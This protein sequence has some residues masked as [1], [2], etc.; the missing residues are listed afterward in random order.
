MGTHSLRPHSRDIFTGRPV[1]TPTIPPTLGVHE[2]LSATYC[3]AKEVGLVHDIQHHFAHFPVVHG[4]VVVLV[5]PL[6]VAEQLHHAGQGFG[7]DPDAVVGEAV[8]LAGL[9]AFLL[10]LAAVLPLVLLG[11][12]EE[13]SHGFTVAFTGATEPPFFTKS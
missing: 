13:R 1:P 4:E 3:H 6:L 2:C 10:Q 8:K 9:H 12:L 11:G 7:D 5:L